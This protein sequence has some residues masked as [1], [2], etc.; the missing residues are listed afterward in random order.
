VN[1]KFESRRLAE[2]ALGKPL[3]K[4]AVIHHIDGS[5]LND[6]PTNL[7]VCPSHAYHMLLHARTRQLKK[8][9]KL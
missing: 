4:G 3:P 9:G 1:G 6:I 8:E 2:K 7:V 5:S